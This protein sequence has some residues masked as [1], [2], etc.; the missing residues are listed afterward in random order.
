M[1]AAATGSLEIIKIL[2]QA[3][4]DPNVM[5][6]S[7]ETA[8]VLAESNG[9]CGVVDLLEG[10]LH[11]SE[12]S[13]VLPTHPLL[14]KNQASEARP[15]RYIGKH[16]LC[17]TSKPAV[18]FFVLRPSLILGDST[19]ILAERTEECI[20]YGDLEMFLLG[21]QLG[22]LL[23]LFKEHRVTFSTLLSMTEED[24]EQVQCLT[25]LSS[26]LNVWFCLLHY[27]FHIFAE[28]H[29]GRDAFT[30]FARG[31]TPLLLYNLQI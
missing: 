28:F 25:V 19:H 30:L 20:Q 21:L 8:S 14:K 1:F 12:A 16:F 6:V 27:V 11:N 18:Y 17:S 23:P 31:E 26:M 13:V 4:A 5:T 29:Q 15:T 3:G 10:V 7:G 9:H 22:D 24:L 2:L